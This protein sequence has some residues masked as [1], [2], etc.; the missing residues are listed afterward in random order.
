MKLEISAI[1][2]DIDK[3]LKRYVSKHIGQLD[4]YAGKAHGPL[5]AHVVLTEND[6][7]AGER[8]VC[9]VTLH[10]PKNRVVAKESTPNSMY[11]AIDLAEEKVKTQMSKYKTKALD[12]KRRL[13]PRWRR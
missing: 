9:E 1:H 12:R 6:G 5:Q 4:K 2:F 11:G 3:K 7:A 10:L 13:W 8:Y